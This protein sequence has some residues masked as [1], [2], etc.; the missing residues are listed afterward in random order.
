[1]K[2]LIVFL[3]FVALIV[4][5]KAQVMTTSLDFSAK[6]YY[7]YTGTTADTAVSGTDAYIYW[8]VPRTGIYLYRVEAELDEISGTANGI[9]ILQG[10]LNGMDWFEVDTLAN[11][12]GTEAQSADATVYLQDLSTGVIWRYMRL[13]VNVSTTAKWDVNYVRFRAVGKLEE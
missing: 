11:T 5:V 2:R 1:M 3:A 10:S 8:G 7:E 9:A 12:A 13:V 4:S 6:H